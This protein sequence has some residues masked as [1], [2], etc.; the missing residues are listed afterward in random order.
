V[1]ALALTGDGSPENSKACQDAGCT[2]LLTKPFRREPFLKTI[3]SYAPGRVQSGQSE[4]GGSA[5]RIPVRGE[6]ELEKVTPR[7]LQSKRED[8]EKLRRALAKKEYEAIHSLGHG[9]KGSGGSYGF[10]EI[11]EFGKRLETTAKRQDADT[12]LALIEDLSR[13]L[14]SVDVYYEKE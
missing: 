1:P 8:V 9:M 13:Y 10:H 6:K 14:D 11:T 12:L 3:A 5:K 4:A 7:Y 2:S